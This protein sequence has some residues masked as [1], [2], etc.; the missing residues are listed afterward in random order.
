M[1][2]VAINPKIHIKDTDQI[3]KYGKYTVIESF[4]GEITV[5]EFFKIIVTHHVKNDKE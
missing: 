4:S 3:S 1:N 2:N 5:E